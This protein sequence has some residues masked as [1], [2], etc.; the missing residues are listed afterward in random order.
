MNR[1]DTKN[2]KKIKEK[3]RALGVLVVRVCYLIADPKQLHAS[4][5]YVSLWQNG[6][7]IWQK[8]AL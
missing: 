5:Y 8:S 7:T 1:K 2:A 4:R 3:L 6:G